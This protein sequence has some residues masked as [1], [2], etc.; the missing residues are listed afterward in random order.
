MNILNVSR[1]N[2][3]K[4]EAKVD[5]MIVLNPPCDHYE[6]TYHYDVEYTNHNGKAL[7]LQILQPVNHV[8]KTPLL[9]FIPGSAFHRQ[10]VRERVPQ[11]ALLAT[12]GIC[13]ALLEYT[14]SEDA[15]FPTLILDAKA[16]VKYMR[17]H[18]KAYNIDEN[19]IFVMGD[20]SGGYT[21]LMTGL[22]NGEKR[23]EDGT[24]DEYKVNGIIDFYGPTDITTMNQ[25][26]S[27][28]NHTEPDSPEGYFIG[29]KDVLKHPELARPTIIRN[30]I[31]KD[32][33]YPPVLMFHGS[34]DELVPFG[35]SC[36]LYRA[37][38]EA[39]K[40]ATLYQIEGAHHGDRQFWS[41]TVLNI[42]EQFIRNH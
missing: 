22:T 27:I 2:F 40:E 35:Q 15:P 6:I 34:N 39:G 16:G 3:P 31:Y 11:L 36:E 5:N 20:S 19:S 10:N 21:A 24:A 33:E 8:A 7:F 17:N 13:V 1:E 26:P 42:I 23:F 18:H 32:K 4:S 28:E 9:I 37:L 25:E 41:Q 30:Y 12:K 38:K 29:R 14:G